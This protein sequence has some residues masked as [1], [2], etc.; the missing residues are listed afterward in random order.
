MSKQRRTLV[1]VIAASQSMLALAE[2]W[3]E[4]GAKAI[5]LKTFSRAITF[6]KQS[7]KTARIARYGFPIPDI[8][9]C[10]NGSVDL[11]WD[12]PAYELLINFPVYSAAWATFYGDDKRGN[13]IKGEFKQ[14]ATA[15]SCRSIMDWL[16][17]RR[18]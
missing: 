1:D 8:T 5:D 12:Y 2:N 16:K 9:P 6:L 10:P 7:A 13:S 17:N 14:T 3:D 18:P 11:H 15:Q 4:D